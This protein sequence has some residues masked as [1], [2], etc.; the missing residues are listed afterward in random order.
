MIS[1]SIF[2]Y[3][4]KALSLG[5]SAHWT[6]VLYILTGQ[7]EITADALFEYYQPLIEWLEHVVLKFNLP[8]GWLDP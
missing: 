5:A 4:R 7:K 1:Y 3:F 6:E 2:L 8:Y